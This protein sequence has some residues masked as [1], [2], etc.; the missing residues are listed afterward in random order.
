LEILWRERVGFS[1]NDARSMGY[2][3]AIHTC[4][5]TDIRNL[6]LYTINKSN[7]RWIIGINKYE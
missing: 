4:R 1:I 2:P 6:A 7:L 5:Q 3:Q